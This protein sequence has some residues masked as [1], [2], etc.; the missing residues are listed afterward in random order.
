[1]W[2]SPTQ[3]PSPC[4]L[5]KTSR[6]GA[7][8]STALAAFT[9]IPYATGLFGGLYLGAALVLGAVFVGLAADLAVRPSRGAAVRLHLASLAYLALLFVAMALDPIL[10]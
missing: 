10:L 6:T 7:S 2:G 5:A 9:V 4:R 8:S 1:M 3:I